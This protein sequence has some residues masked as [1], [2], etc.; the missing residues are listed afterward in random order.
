MNHEVKF[1]IRFCPEDGK[2]MYMGFYYTLEECKQ[3]IRDNK[4][5]IEN[6]YA[7]SYSFV[8]I[9]IVDHMLLMVIEEYDMPQPQE[10]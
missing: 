9:E 5:R 1:D 3:W 6:Y 2:P 10:Y 7:Y 8:R 4:E